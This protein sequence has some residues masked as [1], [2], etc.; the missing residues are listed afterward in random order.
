MEFPQGLRF[1]RDP[2]VGTAVAMIFIY[3]ALADRVRD[4]GR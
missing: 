2:M 3:L 1:L 4:P